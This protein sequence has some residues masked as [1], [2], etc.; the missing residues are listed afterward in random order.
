MIN[1]TDTEEFIEYFKKE[2]SFTANDV[3][4]F[5]NN[6]RQGIKRS[7]V[8]WRIYNYIQQGILRRVGRGVYITGESRNFTP[9]QDEK[10][11]IIAFQI[12]KQFPF[13]TFCSW[14][15]SILKELFQHVPAIN[16]LIV[17]VEKDSLDAVFHFLKESKKNTFKEPSKNIVEDFVCGTDTAIV[18]KTMISESP[19][20]QIDGITIPALEK[21]LVDLYIERD[22]FY[23]LQ[24]IELL[25]VFKN[26][27][28]KYTINRN[29]MLRYAKR[30]GKETEI[31]NILMQINGNNLQ[32]LT[33]I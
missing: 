7:T 21:I 3:Y 11:K 25:N 18:V 14:R 31:E 9:V 15:L 16:F 22:I 1:K 10:Q 28:G 5:F 4:H 30:R 26:A 2:K 33:I 27:A 17:E 8:N 20:L 32:K 13:A 6:I 24:G 29:K 12:K 19:V 23:F